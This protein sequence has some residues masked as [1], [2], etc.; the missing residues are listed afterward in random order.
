MQRRR[1]GGL[2]VSPLVM[3]PQEQAS[4]INKN[5][6]P[7]HQKNIGNLKPRGDVL[8]S[9]KRVSQKRFNDM[10]IALIHQLGI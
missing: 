10:M 5:E 4:T 9:G 3:P 6:V 7:I 1:A 8:Q 2:G